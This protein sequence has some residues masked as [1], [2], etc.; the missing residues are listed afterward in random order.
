MADFGILP[1]RLCSSAARDEV[2]QAGLSPF[3]V[4]NHFSG[5]SAR[6]L[7]INNDILLD[8]LSL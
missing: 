5:I 8:W 3:C 1:K 7:A 6:T 2:L 4:M